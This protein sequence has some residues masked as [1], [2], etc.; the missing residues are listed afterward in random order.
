MQARSDPFQPW[1]YPAVAYDGSA[2]RI[3]ICGPDPTRAERDTTVLY[4]T[5][6]VY[7]A[8]SET[9][10][11]VEETGARVDDAGMT[12]PDPTAPKRRWAV[13]WNDLGAYEDLLVERLIAGR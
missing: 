7:L 2:H 12:I 4:D 6:A 3:D 13:A 10:V 8:Y 1:S 5:V 11:R 9:L